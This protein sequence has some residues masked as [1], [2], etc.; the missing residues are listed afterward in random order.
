M[1]IFPEYSKD[2]A[3][4]FPT[5]VYAF[6]DMMALGVMKALSNLGYSVPEHVSVVGHDNMTQ[7]KYTEPDLTTV[8]GST[9]YLARVVVDSAYNNVFEKFTKGCNIALPVKLIERKTVRDLTKR[10]NGHSE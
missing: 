2:N 4:N 5:S 1:R 3:E 6:N 10:R 7:L 9:E 8:D